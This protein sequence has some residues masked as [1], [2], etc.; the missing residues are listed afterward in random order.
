MIKK[1]IIWPFYFM[2]ISIVLL[3]EDITDSFSPLLIRSHFSIVDS[4]SIF[5]FADL[6][7]KVAN[8]YTM[9][10]LFTAYIKL[11]INELSFKSIH[12]LD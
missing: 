2:R 4:S 11:V 5:G 6:S 9:S 10:F 8:I 3:F 7:V 1:R 12:D